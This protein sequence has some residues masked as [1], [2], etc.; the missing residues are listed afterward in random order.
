MKLRA[1]VKGSTGTAKHMVGELVAGEPVPVRTLPTPAWV[2]I[3]EEEGAF[4]LFHYDAHGMCF[5]DTWHR[6][7]E[8]AKR[9]AEFEFGLAADDWT[10]VP[11]QTGVG[12][13]G[14]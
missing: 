3:A 8:D 2:E 7:L 12:A 4:Y 5:A 9:Q 14:G 6:T 1:T 13:G 10:A 11:V